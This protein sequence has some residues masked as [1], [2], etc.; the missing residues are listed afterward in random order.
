MVSKMT[1]V[2]IANICGTRIIL[3]DSEMGSAIYQ[4]GYY[5]KPVGIRKPRSPHFNR[6]LELSVLEAYYL[7]SLQKIQ[8]TDGEKILSKE[9]FRKKCEKQF[10]HFIDLYLVYTDLRNLGYIV[11]PGL[12]FGTDFGVYQKGPGIDHAPFLVHVQRST[13]KPIDLVR[14]G[15]LATSVRKRYVI[16][17]VLPDQSIR[18]YV[19]SWFKP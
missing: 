17:T 11:R 15:R 7:L 19:F 10:E 3:W 5:G 14:A 18:Y 6:P 13:L 1:E 2:P 16:A 4:L 8:I 12:K 9:E